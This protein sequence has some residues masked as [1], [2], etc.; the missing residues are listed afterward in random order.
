MQHLTT[1]A[2]AIVGLVAAAY[3]HYSLPAHTSK[4]KARWFTHL[5]LVSVGLAFGWA[6]ATV[7]YP[8]E[9]LLQV[10]VFLY[11]FGAVHIPAACILFIKQRRRR[12]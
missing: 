10:L 3:A 2:F 12:V 4:G 5:L 9:G 1:G 7:Y 8:V 11:A 6:V